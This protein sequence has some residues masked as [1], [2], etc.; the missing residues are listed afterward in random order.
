MKANR[1]K[2]K[3]GSALFLRVEN[4][5][6]RVLYLFNTLDTYHL[7][8][9]LVVFLLMIDHWSWRDWW[10]VPVG[11]LAYIIF[12]TGDFHPWLALSLPGPVVYWYF[13]GN[14]NAGVIGGAFLLQLAFFVVIQVVFMGI[15]N[16]VTARDASV[17]LRILWNSCRTIAPTT[18][19]LPISLVFSTFL[20]LAMLA[21]TKANFSIAAPFPFLLI[22][23]LVV[24]ALK[25][26]N[27]SRKL[28]M[29]RRSSPAVPR[30]VLLNIDG[31]R[32]DVFNTIERPAI[33]RFARE[34]TEITSGLRTVYRALTNPAFASILT[35]APPEVHGI[36]NNNLGQ[37]IRVE[38]LP[39]LV[40]TILYGSM[41]VKHFSKPSWNVKTPSIVCA[42]CW[43]IDDL[44]LEELKRDFKERPDVRLFVFDFSEADFV[45]HAYGSTTGFYRRSLERTDERIGR[46]LEWLYS[47]DRGNDTAVIICSDHGIAG[48]DHSY[49]LARSERLVPFIARGP[50]IKRGVRVEAEGTVMDIGVTIAGL[51]GVRPPAQAR[52]RVLREI[53]V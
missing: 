6:V 45:G 27:L 20:T 12:R 52:G 36:F 13:T 28:I 33:R 26:D 38:G 40:P 29:D 49:L 2:K 5:G 22:W 14:L 11:A 21:G 19:S 1:L 53:F 48:I 24:R 25:P 16:G 47:Q 7:M 8:A 32:M 50:G 35:G 44:A 41:H 42:S 43:H 18:V 10:A 15:P 9:G 4:I 39:D 37:K 46:F 3:G 34:G 30:L 31:V 51:L 23:S 17:P